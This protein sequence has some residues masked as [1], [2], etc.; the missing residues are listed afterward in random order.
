MSASTPG[1]PTRA[2]VAPS[3]DD[4]APKRDTTALALVWAAGIACTLTAVTLLSSAGTGALQDTLK[5]LGF[6][7]EKAIE[8]QQRQ[9]ANTIAELERAI[10]NVGREVGA[11]NTRMAVTEH[12]ESLTSEA[13][14]R[15]DGDL[16]VVR[17]EVAD[18]RTARHEVMRLRSSIDAND[19]SSQKTITTLTKRLDKLEQQ[20]ATASIPPAPTAAAKPAKRREKAAEPDVISD[21]MSELMVLHGL[22]TGDGPSG[23]VIDKP[24]LGH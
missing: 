1:A 6:G 19:R 24:N 12:K 7:R 16:N 9:Q 15:L 5:S 3:R 22:R 17:A 18:A 2:T 13:L 10:R 4:V 20:L 11:L 14:Q 23:H 21:A 8:A